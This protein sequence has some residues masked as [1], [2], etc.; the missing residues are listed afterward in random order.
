[1]VFPGKLEVFCCLCVVYMCPWIELH[2]LQAYEYEYL[3]YLPVDCTDHLPGC[4]LSQSTQSKVCQIYA[5][6]EVTKVL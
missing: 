1:M 6:E 3:G 5:E 4:V 2:S